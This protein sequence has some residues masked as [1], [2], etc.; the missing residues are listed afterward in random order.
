MSSKPFVWTPTR[1][2]QL[3][4]LIVEHGWT[5]HPVATKAFGRFHLAEA[6]IK[7]RAAE[8]G[9]E[10][11]PKPIVWDDEKD[12]RLRMMVKWDVGIGKIAFKLSTDED[13]VRQRI[14]ELK[15]SKPISSASGFSVP[16]P[17][18]VPT[19]KELAELKAARKRGDTKRE[20][21][22]LDVDA[23]VVPEDRLRQFLDPNVVDRIAE[24]I[25]EIGQQ[26]PI[27]VR[28]VESEHCRTYHLIAGR[29]R[30]EAMRKL[31]RPT[32]L[33]DVR[34]DDLLTSDEVSLIEI[35]ENLARGNLTPAERVAHIGRRK[36]IYEKLHPETVSVRK[37]GGPGRGKKN[38]SQDATSFPAFVD[39][40]AAVTGKDRATVARDAA[41]AKAIS[42]VASLAG[43]S[44]DSG[45]ELAALA[46]LPAEE[47]ASLIERAKAAKK[48]S[49]R[50]PKLHKTLQAILDLS[51]QLSDGKLQDLLRAEAKATERR[52]LLEELA[53][54]MSVVED[55]MQ[56]GQD[57]I[58]N[59]GTG[60]C[61]T[62][63]QID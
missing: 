18:H 22:A 12:A 52:G 41:I 54:A 15:I 25:K 56:K 7:A 32:I 45:V 37:K 47:Q 57:T 34:P 62:A 6:E 51:S 5:A 38:G 42:D 11:K 28:M 29:Q 24:S 31:G 9:I 23:I 19:E 39:A 48:V 8:L 50:K 10:M 20:I 27:V 26:Q 3:R 2:E 44:L 33:A 63:H 14:E 4:K 46:K 17:V 16:T 43:T 55:L 36:E 58:R 60:D 1:D 49:A 21:L 59:I 53:T 30:L 61:V 40:A 13:C 35:D